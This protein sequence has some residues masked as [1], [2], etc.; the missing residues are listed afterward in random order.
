MGEGDI[1]VGHC[2]GAGGPTHPVP[3]APPLQQQ[4]QQRRRRR[5]RRRRRAPC[6]C[7]STTPPPAGCPPAAGPL[8]HPPHPVCRSVPSFSALLQCPLSVPSFCAGPLSQH[9]TPCPAQC[10]FQCPHSVPSS[11]LPAPCFQCPRPVFSLSFSAAF[12]ALLCTPAS[13]SSRT[14]IGCRLRRYGTAGTATPVDHEQLARNQRDDATLSHPPAR[15]LFGCTGT[16]RP[17]RSSP[18]TTNNSRRAPLPATC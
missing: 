11:F 7:R 4:Q 1:Q 14:P 2:R 6:R 10:G 15:H 9:H 16:A 17:A 18:S 12:T 3:R 8:P 5:R 13:S